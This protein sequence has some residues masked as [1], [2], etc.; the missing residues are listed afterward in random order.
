[1]TPANFAPRPNPKMPAPRADADCDNYEMPLLF[2]I[3][4]LLKSTR[5]LKKISTRILEVASLEKEL[6]NLQLL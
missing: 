2:S 4:K 5:Q 3:V 1:M 6:R